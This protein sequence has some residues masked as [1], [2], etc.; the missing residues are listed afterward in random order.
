VRDFVL[1]LPETTEFLDKTLGLLEFMMPKY[2][3][4]GK[5]YLTLGIGCTGGRHRSVVLTEQ[6]ATLLEEKL[7]AD[8]IVVHR[9][10]AR[11]DAKKYER[12]RDTY[13]PEIPLEE[14]QSQAELVGVMSPA[15]QST[16]NVRGPK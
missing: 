16:H 1:A 13:L 11:G 5:S 9:D 6:I 12:E 7:G 2:E 10:V 15:P 14:R 8:V 3:R 4:E